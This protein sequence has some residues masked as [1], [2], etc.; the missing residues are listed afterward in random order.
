MLVVDLAS[1]T[2]LH[3]FFFLPLYVHSR[4]QNVLTEC[5]ELLALILSRDCWESELTRPR[6]LKPLKKQFIYM[7]QGYCGRFCILALLTFSFEG[8]WKYEFCCD[9]H[10]RQFHVAIASQQRR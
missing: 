10:V 1:R 9:E 7:D 4:L 2:H 8:W 3:V 5:G 6:I